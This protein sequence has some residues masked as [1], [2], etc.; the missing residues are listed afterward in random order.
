MNQFH[1]CNN[2]F[3]AVRRR[4]HCRICGQIFCGVCADNFLEKSFFGFS[5]KEIVRV[6]NICLSRRKEQLRLSQMYSPVMKKNT[7]RKSALS[8]GVARARQSPAKGSMPRISSTAEGLLSTQYK[9]VTIPGLGTNTDSEVSDEEVSDSEDEFSLLNIFWDEGDV[10]SYPLENDRKVNFD[11]RKFSTQAECALPSSSQS[12]AKQQTE[13]SPQSLALETIVDALLERHSLQKDVWLG[14]L[15]ELAQESVKEIGLSEMDDMDV[16]KY[17][18]VKSLPGGNVGDSKFV[19][20]AIVERNVAHKQMQANLENPKVLLMS[21]AI[22]FQK[23]D[24]KL[25]TFDVLMMQ[26]KN[27]L[28]ILVDR[29]VALDPDLLITSETIS[30]TALDYLKAAGIACVTRVKPS[31]LDRLSRFTGAHIVHHLSDIPSAASMLGHRCGAVYTET[32]ESTTRKRTLMFFDKCER[33]LGGTV[34]LRGGKFS[35]DLHVLK[36]ILQFAIFSAYHLRLE[37]SFVSDLMLSCGL[38]RNDPESISPGVKFVA[39]VAPEKLELIPSLVLSEDQTPDLFNLLKYESPSL[40]FDYADVFDAM[41]N[42]TDHYTCLSGGKTGDILENQS[43]VYSFSQHHPEKRSHCLAYQY[44]FIKFYSPND[45]SLSKFLTSFCRSAIPCGAP[46][47]QKPQIEHEL[48]FMHSNSRL[49]VSTTQNAEKCNTSL[50]PHQIRTWFVCNACRSGTDP[51]YLSVE[52]ELLSFGKFLEVLFM[53]KTLTCVSGHEVNPHG[54]LIFEFDE[55]ITTVSF[56]TMPVYSVVPP[57]MKQRFNMEVELSLVEKELSSL[58]SSTRLTYETLKTRAGTL[59]LTDE[60]LVMEKEEADLLDNIQEARSWR[61]LEINKLF[62]LL[63]TN[64][65]RWSGTFDHIAN[66]NHS[67]NDSSSKAKSSTYIKPSKAASTPTQPEKK[68][69]GGNNTLNSPGHHLVSTGNVSNTLPVTDPSSGENSNSNSS[70][71]ISGL[72]LRLSVEG[73]KLGSSGQPTIP[74]GAATPPTTTAVDGAGQQPHFISRI[75]K[76]K[77]NS[78]LQDLAEAFSAVPEEKSSTM[79]QLYAGKAAP[80]PLSPLTKESVIVFD[81]EPSSVIAHALGTD[82][83]REQMHKLLAPLIGRSASVEKRDAVLDFETIS[84]DLFVE[85]SLTNSLYSQSPMK[86][87][88]ESM[89][90]RLQYKCDVTI[91]YPVQFAALR[92]I[93]CGGDAQ[94]VYSMARSQKWLAKEQGGGA[95]KAYFLNSKDGL[96]LLKSVP[97][98][99]LKNFQAFAQ[100]YFEY[101]F[102]AHKS[103]VPTMLVKIVGMFSVDVK[104]PSGL[105]ERQ[106]FIVMEK[107]FHDRTISKTFDLKGSLINRL[108]PDSSMVLQDENL[109]RMMWSNPLVVD[110]VSK[111]MF[112]L[113][114]W[115]DSYFLSQVSVMDYS[116]LVGVDEEKSQL[117]VGIIDYIRPYSWDK[118]LEYALKATLNSGTGKR[119]TVISPND[120]RDRFR[121]ST[122]TYFTLIPNRNTVVL[123]LQNEERKEEKKEVNV[124]VQYDE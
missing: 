81:Q 1:S 100:K 116:I 77:A 33:R 119:P 44:H 115:N 30:S 10:P 49:F 20:G 85:L 19:Q 90:P 53:N 17:V 117:V 97:S 72:S 16:R 89:L 76:K 74:S 95:S 4:H 109:R 86:V 55:Y 106:D 83:Y 65:L 23:P 62:R 73:A 31:M 54:V 21:C 75:L 13:S 91:Y 11:Y 7:D 66:A 38:P 103:E 6:C 15:C 88:F 104:N 2:P 105:N 82:S 122:W 35:N 71:N 92:S 5:E 64:V 18:K 40:N 78:L 27:F 39:P 43:I 102:T 42:P 9:R 70:T 107:L 29:I 67:N 101:L 26:E 79:Y 41:T 8:S 25:V 84:E 48:S 111:G 59:G 56:L 12:P 96:Y 3:T 50:V 60:V 87:S 99:E 98:V 52:A 63:F 108:K 58:A 14:L 61:L 51:V 68:L 46:N 123:Q 94:F 47:C 121:I 45:F 24:W 124:L 112:G 28:Q 113:A 114:I 69:L 118:Q 93:V 34:L 37:E 32:F 120:Y 110:D 22:E 36:S 57:V 80:M